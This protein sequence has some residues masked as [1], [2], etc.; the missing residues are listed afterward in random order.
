MPSSRHSS[1]MRSW[2]FAEPRAAHG[3][4]AAIGSRPVP[5][6]SA[7][8]IARLE[9][10]DRFSAIPQPPRGRKA[11]KPRA[12]YAVIC[13]Q[14]FHASSE[15]PRIRAASRLEPCAYKISRKVGP[16]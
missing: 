10:R 15:L 9:Q 7:D 11:G 2:P 8:A 14:S 1:N 3:D 5:D 4:D 6:A 12:H 16:S 13:L